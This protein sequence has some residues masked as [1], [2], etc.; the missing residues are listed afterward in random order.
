MERRRPW[1]LRAWDS[2]LDGALKRFGPVG[3]GL[4][5][6]APLVLFLA[7]LGLAI[8]WGARQG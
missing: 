2:V 3:Y 8:A 1:P 7:L 6:A 4:A 5:A